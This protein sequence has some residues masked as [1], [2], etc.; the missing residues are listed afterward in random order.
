MMRNYLYNSATN[1]L[2]EGEETRAK[3]EPHLYRCDTSGRELQ[4][5]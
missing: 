3:C 1:A 5:A 4:P 2:L